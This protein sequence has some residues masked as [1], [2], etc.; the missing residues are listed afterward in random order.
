MKYLSKSDVFLLFFQYLDSN[1]IIYCVVGDS[2]GFPSV[3]ES[4]VDIVVPQAL[5]C[6][7]PELVAKFA[8]VTD[9]RLAQIIQHE[10]NAYYCVLTWFCKNKHCN[11]IHLDLSGD[12]VRD[13]KMFIPASKLLASRKKKYIDANNSCYFFTP[14]FANEFLYYFLKRVD[15]NA[16]N[17]TQFSHMRQQYKGDISGVSSVLCERFSSQ[18]VH[19]IQNIM[20]ANDLQGLN[21]INSKI[22][23]EFQYNLG[24]IIR[25]KWQDLR[26]VIK[27]VVYPTGINICFLGPDGSGKSSVI[28]RILP[29]I[30][31]I[32]RKQKYIHLRPKLG[33]KNIGSSE[34]VENPHAQE[35][36][37]VVGSLLKIVYFFFDYILG[38]FLKIRPMLVRSTCVVFDRYYY[39]LLVDPRRYRYG[40]SMNFANFVGKFI[41]KPDLVILLDAPADVLQQRKQEVP[42]EETARQRDVYLMLVKAMGN[43]VVID[44]S[45]PLDK[46]VMDVTEVI[47]EK[48][49]KKTEKNLGL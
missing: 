15:K 46:V 9:L 22:R 24:V 7:I 47:I 25:G 27:R 26:R 3:I 18:L 20:E 11:M 42:Y 19:E 12:Y 43:G 1:S 28:D 6:N 35:L 33:Y 2:S 8:H 31:P 5:A 48:M 29:V 14:S 23:K 36:R 45:Q 32:Y 21:L 37:G 13:N 49:A 30:E 4:D 34:K 41:P 38:Y 17:A 10:R 44:S 39:D 16:V 40:A